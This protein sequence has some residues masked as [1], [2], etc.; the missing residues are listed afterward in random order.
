MG[1][2]KSNS[3]MGT[4]SGTGF[5]SMK[6]NSISYITNQGGQSGMNFSRAENPLLRG[7]PPGPRR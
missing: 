4:L 5:H 3:T 6:Q 7:S 2:N 1:M